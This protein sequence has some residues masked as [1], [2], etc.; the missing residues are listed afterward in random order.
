MLTM[1]KK[2]TNKNY[3]LARLGSLKMF[4][5]LR[6]RLM[7]LDFYRLRGIFKARNTKD[8]AAAETTALRALARGT[9]LP[10]IFAGLAAFGLYLF[11]HYIYVFTGWRLLTNN[12]V[13]RYLK[14]PLDA[15]SYVQLLTTVAAVTGVFL[16]LYFTAVSTVI[17]NAYSN[18]PNDI[19]E[20]LIKDRLGNV[21]VKAVS[22]LTAFSVILLAMSAGGGSPLHL[23]PPL[24]IVLSGF[25]V[26]AFARLGQRAFFLSDRTLLANTISYELKRWAERSTNKGWNWRD[27]NFQEHYRKQAS[28]SVST[29]TA[30]ARISSTQPELQ[31]D[32]YA[33]L[34]NKLLYTVRYYHDLKPLIPSGSRWFG[35]KYEHQQ[36]YLSESTTLD[37]ASQ[38]DTAL[39]PNEVPNV[40]WV[41]EELLGV[42]F[43]SLGDEAG[44][45]HYEA[46][47]KMLTS[48]PDFF[49]SV[50]KNWLTADGEVWCDKVTE[51][52]IKIIATQRPIATDVRPAY[53]VAVADICAALPVSLELGFIKAVGD[54]DV[55]KLRSG[56]AKTDWTKP[57]SPYKFRLPYSTINALE[58]IQENANFEKAAQA[59]YMS[60]AWYVIEYTF[61]NL[62]WSLFR[63][64]EQLLKL[65]ERW[66][67]ATGEELASAGQH[68]HAA[69]VY[70][71]ALELAWKLDSHIESLKKVAE[72]LR[73]G[74]KLDFKRPEWDWENAH[75][76]VVKFRNKAIDEMAKLIP[77]LLPEP[78]DSDMPDYFG[79]A[80]HKTGEACFDALME[81]DADR[82]KSLFGPYF[83]GI[84][85]TFDKV[86]PQVMEWEPSTALTWLA[87]PI[88]DL[89]DISGYAYILAEFH[90]K[91]ELWQECGQ[92]WNAYLAGNN[93][94]DRLKLLA[95][96][97]SHYQNLFGV[98]SPRATLRSQ[99]Q[100]RL[101]RLFETLPRRNVAD[102][103][104]D[105]PIVHDSAFI[106]NIAPI[107]DMIMF[108]DAIDIFTVKFLMTLPAANGLDFGVAQSKID[109]IKR[110]E[111][112]RQ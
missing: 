25:A 103:F 64:W 36:W 82:F 1:R 47:Y 29:L 34:L 19:R 50:G 37:M 69:A 46:I 111:E 74:S 92:V 18:V 54:I 24:L 23:V 32:A 77:H 104:S 80:V 7:K 93:Q 28:K 75:E 31:G 94:L 105:P 97:S 107:R 76:R 110:D 72:A 40:N 13:G 96:L 85:G 55:D 87:E 78:P 52:V 67:F 99:R 14:N 11:D 86:R 15:N 56:L 71:R 84:L 3:N 35:K 10:I 8:E 45:K 12:A 42:L 63:Q 73:E 20:L 90:G 26:F 108:T 33:R 60:P 70:T 30:L 91:P 102:P 27:I 39:S 51:K 89:F 66:Y 6:R 21:Y 62:D 17:A 48:F 61:N 4:W 100:I 106:R 5:Q 49:D 81:G 88:I 79:E 109:E 112:D 9:Y 68:K 2:L 44:E 83:I 38:T 16:G 22:F 59:A 57:G 58:Q 101:G 41:E 53:V 95:G 98:L 65:I 43:D